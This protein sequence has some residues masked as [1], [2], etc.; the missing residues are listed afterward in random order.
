[1]TQS[2]NPLRQFFRQ[3]AIYLKLPSAGQYWPAASLDLPANGEL[4]IYPMTAID[5]ITYRTPDALYNGQAVVNVIQSCIP[6]IHDAWQL[7]VVDLNAVLVAIRIAS[8]GHKMEFLSKCPQCGHDHEIV[9]DLRMVLEQIKCPDYN[10]Q[11]VTGDMEIYFRP[12][13]YKNINDNK[14]CDNNFYN[15]NFN[16]NDFNFVNVNINY[17]NLVKYNLHCDLNND[18]NIVNDNEHHHENYDENSYN[19]DA[20]Q[21]P[22]ND[23]NIDKTDHNHNHYNFNFN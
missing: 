3:P 21:Y 22:N 5:E 2:H 9:A 6:V 10:K 17:F 11:I 1:M 20:K 12:M 4:P 16:G 23:K 15:N 7:P 18:D 19:I 8:Y 14:P 13:S